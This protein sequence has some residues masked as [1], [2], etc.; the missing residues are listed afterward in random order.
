VPLP[1][2]RSFGVS[3]LGLQF[4]CIVLRPVEQLKRFG[5][6]RPRLRQSQSDANAMRRMVSAHC[7]WCCCLP[8]GWLTNISRID[9]L[10]V[11]SLLRFREYTRIV[12]CSTLYVYVLRVYLDVL[13]LPAYS[14]HRPT[15][16]TIPCSTTLLLLRYYECRCLFMHHRN[17]ELS[18]LVLY[19]CAMQRQNLKAKGAFR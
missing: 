3:L 13:L 15:F 2:V 9:F 4:Y 8:L 12:Q 7:V 14:M 5:C 18:F 17:M 6:G 11:G 19:M 16:S 1:S 10:F